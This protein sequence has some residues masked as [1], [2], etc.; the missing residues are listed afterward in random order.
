MKIEDEDEDEDEDFSLSSEDENEL[1]ALVA[2]TDASNGDTKRK[3]PP[4]DDVSE[5]KRLAP[6]VYPEKSALA[7]EILNRHFGL[8]AFRH[9]Q[10]VVISRLLYG[11]SAVVIFPTGGG[12]SLCYQVPALAFCEMDKIDDFSGPGEEGITIVISPLIA[13]MK[14]QVDALVRRGIK[15]ACLDSTK[16]Q[17][18]YDEVSE[19]L[20]QGTLKL[21]YCAPERLNNEGFI[22]QLRL[23]RGGIRMVAV[24]E[25]HC[26]SEWGHDF[27]PDYLKISRF[28]KELKAER[29][30]CLTATATPRVAQDIC[31]TFDIDETGLFRTSTY[32]HNLYLL[33]EFGSTKER[34]YPRLFEFLREHPGPS[35]VYVMGKKQT[36]KL[37]RRL[38]REGFKSRPFN[39]G[40]FTADKIATQ[41]SFMKSD[42]LIIVATIAFGMGIDKADIRNVVHFDIPTSLESYSQEIGRAGRDGKPSFCVFYLCGEDLHDRTIYARGDLP[43][44]HSFRGLLND[45]FKATNARLAVGKKLEASL[46][47]QEKRFDIQST[48]LKSIYAQ[49]ELRHGLF[50]AVTPVYTDY[51]YVAVND[52]HSNVA[53]DK[54]AATVAIKN[55]A[56]LANGVY[57]VDTHKA[58]FSQGIPRTDVLQ[59]LNDWNENRVIRI[60]T[61]GVFSVYRILKKLPSTSSEI[62]AI[63]NDL[64]PIYKAREHQA[65]IRSEM[66][67]NLIRGSACFSQALVQHFG[68]DLPDGRTECGH[69]TWCFEH[70]PVDLVK[71]PPVPFNHEKFQKILAS[72][73]VRNDALFLTRVAF[74]IPSPRVTSMQLYK[75]SVYRSMR[76]H[77]FMVRKHF[78]FV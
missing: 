4:T 18:N 72:I 75:S 33:A 47:D 23:A 31:D 62:D 68:D 3:E 74:G 45:I 7:V 42:D 50:R 51:Q 41:D 24:D 37:A 54:S 22:E 56:V 2:A 78:Y 55:F 59:K 73:P 52:Y 25:A 76:D 15:A 66:V 39:A 65:L 10:E 11:G 28:V 49:L 38:R 40:M 9:K 19:T 61:D 46:Y 60:E 77:D 64:Y 27:R 6:A 30:V 12:K 71:P 67:I 57:S 32:R 13:L 35:I 63:M 5:S 8:N 17:G 16:L 70:R 1:V 53:S 29:V 69:C 34:L 58:A 26:I 48:T 44:R 20:R 14:D 43:S 36:R 21:L